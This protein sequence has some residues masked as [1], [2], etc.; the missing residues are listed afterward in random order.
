L[1]RD[2]SIHWKT[3][4]RNYTEAQKYDQRAY[5]SIGVVIYEDVV[6]G[7]VFFEMFW[8]YIEAEWTFNEQMEEL[9]TRDFPFREVKVKQV[10]NRYKD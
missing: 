4:L 7:E 3:A 9:L 2:D 5:K 1:N 8:M 6:D 10:N